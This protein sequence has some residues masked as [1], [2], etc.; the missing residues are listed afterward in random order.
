MGP[1]VLINHSTVV[2]DGDVAALVVAL[3]MQLGHMHTAGWPID[4]TVSMLKRGSKIPR[5]AIPINVVD[6]TDQADA[7]GYHDITTTGQPIGYV[8]A[9]TAME[10]G[11]SWTVDASHEVC[12]ILV[13]P[14]CELATDLGSGLWLA[15]EVCDPVQADAYGYTAPNGVLLSDF[16]TPAWFSDRAPGPYDWR[17][18]LIASLTVLPGGY[19]SLQRDGHWEQMVSEHSSRASRARRIEKR[20][21]L[22][23]LSIGYQ[24]S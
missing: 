12:E 3:K 17:F 16:V 15:Y 8:F 14:Y 19:V 10:A 11:V 7:L 4:T 22:D 20:R 6:D 9:R 13:D 5:N 24:A 2:T 1:L 21:A 18:H 23:E